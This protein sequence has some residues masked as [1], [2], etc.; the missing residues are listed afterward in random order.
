MHNP[1]LLAW[2][3]EQYYVCKIWNVYLSC[4]E[5]IVTVKI[6]IFL[7]EALKTHLHL[8]L[9]S[10]KSDVKNIQ[11]LFRFLKLDTKQIDYS[12]QCLLISCRR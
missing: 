10:S 11:C 12:F 9:L 8:S 6:L 1:A 3:G 7:W 2:R 5:Q 4:A